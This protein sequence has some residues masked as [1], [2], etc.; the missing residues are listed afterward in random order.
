V[1][2]PPFLHKTRALEP[3]PDGLCRA[4]TGIGTFCKNR[5]EPGKALC[6]FHENLAGPWSRPDQVFEKF[7][8]DRRNP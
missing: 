2:F 4:R 6:Y 7:S 8:R 1:K 5:A 3:S